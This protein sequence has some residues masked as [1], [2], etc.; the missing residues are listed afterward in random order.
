MKKFSLIILIFLFIVGCS[1]TGNIIPDIN[2]VN[3]ENPAPSIS[4]NNQEEVESIN[5]LYPVFTRDKEKLETSNW[6]SYFFDIHGIELHV[7]FVNGSGPSYVFNNNLEGVL[8]LTNGTEFFYNQYINVVLNKYEVNTLN[9]YYDEYNWY[10]YIDSKYILPVTK[11]DEIKAVPCISNQ[12]AIPRYYNKEYLEM[13]DMDVPDTISEFSEYLSSVN[14]I[15]SSFYPMYLNVFTISQNTSDIF[16]AFGVYIGVVEESTISYNP[17]TS[18][19]EDGVFSPNFESGL[20]YIRMLEDTK[21]LKIYNFNTVEGKPTNF[22]FATE[23][24][25][26]SLYNPLLREE[27]PNYEFLKG[28]YLV[29]INHEY[30][31]PAYRNISY[32]VFL[33]T[34]SNMD[35]TVALFNELMTNRNYFYDLQYG[36]EGIDYTLSNIHADRN[37]LLQINQI[38]PNENPIQAEID[39]F[40][41]LNALPEKLSYELNSNTDLFN[42]RGILSSE[43]STNLGGFFDIMAPNNLAKLFNYENSVSDN[44]EVYKNEFSKYQI[45]NIIRQ[46]NDYLGFETIYDYPSN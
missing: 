15:D 28:Y 17:I 13:L 23:E 32:Y 44:I 46:M 30:L 42:L 26:T 6:E 9:K 3:S 14:Q 22:Q 29:G 24:K 8:Y 41:L 20:Q 34:I 19:I 5:I 11:N 45:D 7:E 16:R 27:E 35:G 21:L 25:R 40:Q 1:K 43:D 10:Q 12:L 18:S 38:I 4:Q 37:S 39:S 36:I 33:E 31:V 2:Q